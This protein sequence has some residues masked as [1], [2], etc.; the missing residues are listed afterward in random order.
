[1]ASLRVVIQDHL[2]VKKTLV[3]LPDDVPMARLLPALATRMQLPLQQG[4][5][6]VLYRLDHRRSGRRLDDRDTMQSAGVLPDDLL[7]LLPE[8]TAA[9]GTAAAAARPAHD[10]R[11]R[12][13][14]SDRRRLEELTAASDLIR[15]VSM[16]GEP[17]ED[18]VIG[19]ACKGLVAPGLAM[20]QAGEE[21]QVQVVLPAGYPSAPPQLR[22]LTPIFHP[23][24]NA[25]GT[26]VCID[27][28]FPSQFLDDLCILLGRMIQYRNYNP[29]SHLNRD[30][31]IWAATHPHLLPIDRRPLRR[32][33]L[34]DPE[35]VEPEIRLL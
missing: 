16:A 29:Y 18:Y 33:E 26:R 30:A 32:G 1:M 5:N 19:F 9:G 15:I 4:G 2:D 34:A 3:E 11:D 24:V 25:E 10:V 23:N 21:H 14:R 6:P 12:R 22:W 20:P 7:M 28:W 17:P 31:A 13:L 8:V 27:V 35:P